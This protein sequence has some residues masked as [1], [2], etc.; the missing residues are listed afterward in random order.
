MSTLGAV[1]IKSPVDVRARALAA[2]LLRGNWKGRRFGAREFSQWR[3]ALPGD[4]P[5][6]VFKVFEQR[7]RAARIV[8]VGGHGMTRVYQ[9]VD[10]A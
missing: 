3:K 9:W 7:K 10:D 8:P 6:H 5:Y 2:H 1:D 4:L